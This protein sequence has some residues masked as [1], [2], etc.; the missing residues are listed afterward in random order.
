MP[1]CVSLFVCLCMCECIFLLFSIHLV[2]L[3]SPKLSRKK[4]LYHIIP[5]LLSLPL[6]KH[7]Q[8]S[9]Y[10]IVV[11]STRLSLIHIRDCKLLVVVYV[12]V[13]VYVS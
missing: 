1:L 7:I 9:E 13:Y 5:P 3:F 6:V 8:I 4:H 11:H 2:Y 10:N 12:Y